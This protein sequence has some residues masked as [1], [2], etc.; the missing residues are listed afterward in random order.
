MA[1]NSLGAASS[2]IRLLVL[3]L[4][5]VFVVQLSAPAAHAQDAFTGVWRAGNDAHYLW[6]GVDWDNF[7]AKWEELSKQNLRL[8]DVETWGEGSQRKYSGVWRA[9]N[10]AHFLW[11]GVDWDNFKAKWEELA[12]QNLRLTVVKTYMEGGQRKYLGVWRA[13]NDGHYLWAGVDWNNFHAKWEELSKQG[14]RLVDFDTYMDGNTRKYIGAW[15]AGNDG[16]FLWV[17]VDWNNFKAKWEEL[18][19]QGLRLTVIR[20]YMDG[21]Q[22]KYAGVWRAG[23]EGYY[24]WDN[25][26]FENFRAKWNE[27][28]GQGLRLVKLVRCPGCGSDCANQLIAK[29]PYIYYITGHP[30]A[31]NWPVDTVGSDKFVRLSAVT[32][33]AAPFTL[34]FSDTSVKRW[35]GW[36]YGDGRYHHAVDYAV[37]LTASFQIK[38]AAPGKVIF[39]GWDNWSGNTVVI[40]HDVGGV[41]DA[42]RTIYMH[43]RNGPANDCS[44]AWANTIPSL[45]GSGLTSY[46]NHLN[47]TGCP[48]AAANQHPN[49]TNWGTN[50]QTIAVSVN[51]QVAAGT[52]LGWAGDTGPGGNGNGNATPNTHLHIFFTRRDPSNGQFYFID[53]YGFYAMPNCYP[54]GNTD[55]IG[56]ACARYPDGWKGGK[57]QY[58]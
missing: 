58:P 11:A 15:R 10:D 40:S 28:A 7:K 34:P 12:K 49:A 48:Q 54:A 19:K 24:L 51:Q 45:S 37:D 57:P 38:A 53:P 30:T 42:F 33:S 2:P 29:D 1:R 20:V 4:L 16:H 17:G 25:V 39:I 13:G 22:K 21:G 46:K 31:Y 50:N 3:S 43:M 36:R 9:G 26:D 14:L 47:T 35:N 18:G 23:N 52:I 32:Y 41:Q 27:L 8:V 5:L 44:K 55:A 56:G 6:V